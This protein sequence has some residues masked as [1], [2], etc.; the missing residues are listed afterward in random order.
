M[1]YIVLQVYCCVLHC[2]TSVLLFIAL[3]HKCIAVYC[4]ALQVYLLCIVSQAFCCALHCNTSVVHRNT[5]VLLCIALYYNRMVL[6]CIALQVYCPERT[7]VIK[8]W[9]T[10]QLFCHL[11]LVSQPVKH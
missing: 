4:I 2:I 6:Y 8:S 7:K 10:P 5:S 1:Y 3:Y 9:L 11:F